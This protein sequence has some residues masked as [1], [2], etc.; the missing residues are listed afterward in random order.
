MEVPHRDDQD[1]FNIV[2]VNHAVGESVK[3]TPPMLI[4]DHG[5]CRWVLTDSTQGLDEF[6]DELSA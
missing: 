6:I 5:P 3:S 1:F 4:V 2:E